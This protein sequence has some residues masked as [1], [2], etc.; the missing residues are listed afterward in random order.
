MELGVVKISSSLVALVVAGAIGWILLRFR[1]VPRAMSQL[2]AARGAEV[3]IASS[4]MV[5]MKS[6]RSIAISLVVSPLF[7]A[8]IYGYAQWRIESGAGDPAKVHP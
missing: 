6:L 8:L 4:N 3:P 1:Y 7:V 5:V 2:Q